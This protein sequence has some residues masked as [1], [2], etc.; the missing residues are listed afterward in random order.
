MEKPK[1][2]AAINNS[3]YII[4][5][6][7][8]IIKLGLNFTET[9]Y[10]TTVILD[11]IF[12]F[13]LL[14]CSIILF[15]FYKFIWTRMIVLY[16]VLASFTGGL[17]TSILSYKSIINDSKMRAIYNFSSYTKLALCLAAFVTGLIDDDDDYH[18]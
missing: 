3:L 16:V 6:F 7:F 17:I 9:V 13:I 2:I 8:T 4:I 18:Y 14:I 12:N 10:T 11:I 15:I 5:F 1:Y